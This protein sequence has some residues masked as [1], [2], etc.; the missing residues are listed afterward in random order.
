MNHP[1]F[2]T[3]DAMLEASGL[4]HSDY[5]AARLDSS[6]TVRDAAARFGVGT[7]CVTKW[8]AQGRLPS[9]KIGGRRLIRVSDIHKLI[10]EGSP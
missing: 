6:V 9:L 4:G 8:I 7:R 2:A 5:V 10:K 3:I 1:I